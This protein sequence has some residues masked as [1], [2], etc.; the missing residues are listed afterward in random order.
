[1]NADHFDVSE[2]LDAAELQRLRDFGKWIARLSFFDSALVIEKLTSE[3]RQAYYRIITGREAHVV[4]LAKQIPMWPEVQI[5]TLLL[6]P[7]TAA[8][9]APALLDTLASAREEVGRLRGELAQADMR[10]ERFEQRATEA[11]TRLLENDAV[12]AARD[13]ALAEANRCNAELAARLADLISQIDQAKGEASEQQQNIER[14]R[15]EIAAVRSDLIIR[16]QAL[17][18]AVRLADELAVELRTARVELAAGDTALREAEQAAAEARVERDQLRDERDRLAREGGRWF[19]AAILAPAQDIVRPPTARK[20][21]LRRWRDGL[22]ED[23]KPSLLACADRARDERHW[24]QAARFYL[25]V[26]RRHPERTA[27]WVQLG[28]ALKEAGKISEAEFAYCRAV[29]LD[30]DH[31]DAWVSLGEVLKRLDRKAEAEAAYVR[32]I[33]L[34]PADHQRETISHELAALGGQ[35]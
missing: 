29:R 5:K 7:S 28:H 1:M 13:I 22:Y 25:D 14:L 27:I 34:A 33:E 35:G 21:L 4:D 16:D 32:A 2:H 6:P 23:A 12:L 9:F 19:E 17:D 26:L 10:Y 24:E 15:D 3:K 31:F 11:E 30:A 8:S 20:G 18:D